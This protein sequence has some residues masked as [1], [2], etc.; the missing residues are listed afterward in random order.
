M[1]CARVVVACG[2]VLLI[3]WFLLTRSRGRLAGVAIPRAAVQRGGEPTF[4]RDATTAQQHPWGRAPHPTEAQTAEEVVREKVSKFGQSRRQLAE[5]L[6][7]RHGLTVPAE[8]QAFFTA[9]ESGDWTRIKTAFN[10]INGGDSSAGHASQRSPEVSQLWPAII[11]AFGAAEQ[12]HLMPAQTLLDYGHSILDSLRPG[13]VYVG[14][15]DSSRWVPALLNDTEEGD[16]HIVITQ[17]G[18]ADSRYLEYVTVQF[19]DRM[20][21][22]SDDESHALFALYSE[23]ARRRLEHDQNFPDEPKQLRRNE[24]VKMVDG[25]LDVSGRDAVFDMN[26]RLL[27]KLLEK[28]PDLSFAIG[29]SVPLPGTY[30]DAVPLGPL[31]ELRAN[32]SENFTAERAA[33]S[34]DRWRETAQYVLA[35]PETVKSEEAMKSYSHDAVAS[36]RLLAAHGFNTEAE[37]AFRLSQQLFPS[38]PEAAVSLAQ[39]YERTGRASEAQRLLEEFVRQHP[40]E[41]KALKD[42]WGIEVEPARR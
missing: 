11:D 40:S 27:N 39:H 24:N 38:N 12:A 26:E 42:G 35:N 2:C 7:Q 32:A 23:D 20:Q 36:A 25:K 37:E 22:L 5:K 28:N 13:M 9:V 10:A 1:R 6:A 31:M 16:K 14:G 18:L 19:S 3:A 8:V 41:Q 21:T 17:N 15:T 33:E 30:A 29:E 34:V 4:T